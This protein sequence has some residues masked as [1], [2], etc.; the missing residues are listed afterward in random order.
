M[1]P[2]C[3]FFRIV[4]KKKEQ[5]KE[6]KS[7]FLLSSLFSWIHIPQWYILAI[8]ALTERKLKLKE[9]DPVEK[10]HFCL[11]DLC[12]TWVTVNLLFL[13]STDSVKTRIKTTENNLNLHCQYLNTSF[14]FHFQCLLSATS[15]SILKFFA[16]TNQVTKQSS[17]DSHLAH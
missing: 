11:S 1:I 5:S 10:D 16:S 12:L 2:Q 14:F 4:I 6:A 8:I 3:K 13:Y 9:M 15:M 17:W 7:A